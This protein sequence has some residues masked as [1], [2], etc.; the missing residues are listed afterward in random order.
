M[1]GLEV[2]LDVESVVLAVG[3]NRDRFAQGVVG[4]EREGDHDAVVEGR[5]GARD[6]A[7]LVAA[8]VPGRREQEQTRQVGAANLDTRPASPEPLDVDL[9]HALVGA[10]RLG[11]WT[12][13]EGV[14]DDQISGSKL[15]RA[16]VEVG[17]VSRC[18]DH[19]QVRYGRGEQREDPERDEA[20]PVPLEVAADQDG[21]RHA[22]HPISSRKCCNLSRLPESLRS[23]RPSLRS[24]AITPSRR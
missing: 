22:H 6:N 5:L 2:A 9:R 4:G 15:L 13:R 12:P 17:V 21:G 8:P 11:D 3:A 18:N 7:V 20:A 10:Q 24:P 1:G 16:A 19:R 14:Q 23:K